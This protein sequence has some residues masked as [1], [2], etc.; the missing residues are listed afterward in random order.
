MVAVGEPVPAPLQQL[1]VSRSLQNVVLLV[2]VKEGCGACEDTLPLLDAA[3]PLVGP[4]LVLAQEDAATVPALREALAPQLTWLADPEPHPLSR[5]LHVEFTPTLVLARAGRVEDVTSGFDP[6]A[7][8][9]MLGAL[10]P[11]FALFAPGEA[12]PPFRPG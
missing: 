7:L 8:H 6:D 9:R 4:L 5:S 11:G 10:T 1:L 3:G 12:R 2:V